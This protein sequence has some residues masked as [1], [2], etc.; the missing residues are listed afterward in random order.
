MSAV[1]RSAWK[2][3][4]FD[5]AGDEPPPK[6]SSAPRTVINTHT[7]PVSI[8]RRP[9]RRAIVRW[10]MDCRAAHDI[11]TRYNNNSPTN[12]TSSAWSI[13]RRDCCVRRSLP[14]AGRRPY[15][16]KYGLSSPPHPYPV[17]PPSPVDSRPLIATARFGFTYVTH[18]SLSLSSQADRGIVLDPDPHVRRHHRADRRVDPAGAADRGDV[19]AGLSLETTSHRWVFVGGAARPSCRVLVFN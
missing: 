6:G 8:H 19:Q 2:R 12:N 9:P 3:H 11:G 5:A 10:V 14:T 16:C 15:V 18:F 13:T 1:T 17:R 4:A 7:R